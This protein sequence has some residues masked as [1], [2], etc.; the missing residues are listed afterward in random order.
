MYGQDSL[1]IRKNWVDHNAS[2]RV[3]LETKIH[4]KNPNGVDQNAL[5]YII[6]LSFWG[7]IAVEI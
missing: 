5:I 4:N 6:P 2:G 1:C 7:V 3:A